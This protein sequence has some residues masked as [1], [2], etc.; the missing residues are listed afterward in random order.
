MNSIPSRINSD[1]LYYRIMDLNDTEK[2]VKL[3]NAN[4][5]RD[6][7]IYQKPITVEEHINYYHTQ[8]ETGHIIQYVMIIPDTNKIVGC[9][10]LKNIDF[11]IK[12]AEYGVFIGDSE[13]LGK[14]YGA[15]ALNQMINIAF[16]VLKLNTLTL[17]V[18][19]YNRIALKTYINAGF[20]EKNRIVDENKESGIIRE[21]IIMEM[22]NGRRQK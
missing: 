8:I 2:V 16:N 5:V 22:I 3:R 17:Q 15:D 18:L 6:N 13:E 20:V 19:S 7:Y 21:V 1:K 12:S 9:V 4:H 14:G 11:D 10:F